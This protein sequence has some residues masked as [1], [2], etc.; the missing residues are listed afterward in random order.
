MWVFFQ[1]HVRHN[2]LEKSTSFSGAP[3][4][5]EVKHWPADQVVL[6]SSAAGGGNLFNHLWGSTA[7]TLSLPP[8]I[9]IWLKNC[10]KGCKTSSSFHQPDYLQLSGFMWAR[11]SFLFMA[12]EA[13]VPIISWDIL[14][15]GQEILCKMIWYPVFL[16]LIPIIKKDIR[17]AVK[18]LWAFNSYFRVRKL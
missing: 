1:I 5:Q 10:R 8:I 9:L 16:I 17:Q 11:S 14:E 18:T 12:S 2:A 15:R 13:V 3:T 4:S 6:V 7:Q